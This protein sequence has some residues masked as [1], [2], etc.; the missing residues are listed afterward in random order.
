MPFSRSLS[1]VE[2]RWGGVLLIWE[3]HD[4][5]WKARIVMWVS[6]PAAHISWHSFCY[7][8]E[9][10][11]VHFPWA[12]SG[13]LKKFNL[14]PC[15]TI[16]RQADDPVVDDGDV[17]WIDMPRLF[18]VHHKGYERQDFLSGIEG[19]MGKL[20]LSGLFGNIGTNYRN[21]INNLVLMW[22]W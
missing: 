21:I 22:P 12:C 14:R 9:I 15:Q 6:W 17:V 10:V 18:Q 16:G 11:N 7:D 4:T 13:I 1:I 2:R 8:L 20:N 3:R 19:V 5:I